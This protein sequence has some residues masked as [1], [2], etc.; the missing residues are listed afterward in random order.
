MI[1]ISTLIAMAVAMLGHSVAPDSVAPSFSTHA[2]PQT[3]CSLPDPRDYTAPFATLPPIH[4]IPGR[5]GRGGVGNLPFGPG[6]VEI[7]PLSFGEPVLVQSEEFGDGFSDVGFE[8]NPP[9]PLGR[10]DWLVRAQ[11]MALDSAGGVSEEVDHG[12]IRIKHIDDSYQPSLS[13][14]VPGRI[15]FYRYDIQFSDFDGNTLGSYSQYVRVVP[16]SARVRL[17]IS[18]RQFRPGQ[19]VATRPEELGTDQISYGEDFDVQKRVDGRWRPYPPMNQHFWAFWRGFAEAGG[20]GSCSSFTIPAGTP[21]GRYRVVKHVGVYVGRKS[22]L[23][24]TLT[25]PFSVLA[26][27]KRNG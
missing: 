26:S 19:T 16:R 25:A 23:G 13:L 6:T 17:G 9:V 15:G 21:K 10:V 11:L 14:K 2:K 22:T 4:E 3:F 8:R 24:V 27:R 1:R 5:S 18:G 12:R 20:A 7:Y